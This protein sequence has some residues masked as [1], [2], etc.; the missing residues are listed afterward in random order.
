MTELQPADFAAAPGYKA[1]EQYAKSKA[2]F[3]EGREALDKLEE[4]R[5]NSGKTN[6]ENVTERIYEETEER[7]GIRSTGDLSLRTMVRGS[8]QERRD[9]NL[10]GNENRGPDGRTDDV[11]S[12]ESGSDAGRH[13]YESSRDTGSIKGA[14]R[15][16]LTALQNGRKDIATNLF[17]QYVLAK[18][19][20]AITPILTAAS[21]RGNNVRVTRD[22]K[23]GEFKAV[24]FAAEAMQTYL[25]GDE[26]LVPIPSSKGIATDTLVLAK[27]L[28]AEAGCKV[29]DILESDSRESSYA[30]KQ[31]GKRSLTAD[32]IGTRLKDGV[33]LTNDQIKRIVFID[34]VIST[35]ATAKAAH[36]A[37]G[38]GITLAFS[39]GQA[40]G[41]PN[42]APGI[43][44]ANPV[45]YDDDG[46]VIPLSQRF[47]T[48]SNDIRYSLD[49]ASYIDIQ[50][51]LGAVRN[52]RAA[53]RQREREIGDNPEYISAVED[54][55]NQS[56][57]VTALAADFRDKLKNKTATEEEKTLLRTELG[58][59]KTKLRE[60]EDYVQ[61]IS[62]G[63]GDRLFELSDRENALRKA[64]DVAWEREGAEK[65][66]KAIDKS[67]LSSEDYFRKK[68]S[69]AF[70]YTINF[71]EAGYLLPN[72]EMLDFSDKKNGAP[73]GERARDHREIGE[74]YEATSHTAA[75][76]RFMADGNVRVMAE[77]PGVDIPALHE[78]TP[79]Q[80][81]Q[82]TKMVKTLGAKE[83]AFYID[84]SDADGRGNGGYSYDGNVNADRVINDIKYFYANGS[85][86]EQ[87]P[88]AQFLSEW[89]N[90]DDVNNSEYE[91]S[92]EYE[93]NYSI[94]VTDPETLQQLADAEKNG[95]TM[96]VYRA[97]QAVPVDD[98]GDPYT[99]KFSVL[100][101]VSF[102]PLTVEVKVWR[103]QGKKTVTQ[104]EVRPAKLFSPMAGLTEKEVNGEKKLVWRD[105]IE[106]GRWDMSE[107]HPE[108]A[109]LEIDEETG[110]Y[111]RGKRGELAWFYGLK[112]G[113][114]KENGKNKTDVGARYNP[115]F[116]V[117]LSALND[118][119][120]SAI[121]RP[122]LVTVLCEIPIPEGSVVKDAEVWLEKAKDPLVLCVGTKAQLAAG[123]QS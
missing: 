83:G 77:S 104:I 100:R 60:L 47:N 5:Y 55:L 20:K 90:S 21:Y 106:L 4:L 19:P 115:Y 54:Y 49:T 18:A 107:G 7:T 52:E 23:S 109:Y 122:E 61:K 120:T 51:E 66:Q 62:E 28:A 73:A 116:H 59:E 121:D 102:D 43:K 76:N 113:S 114:V 86:R 98:N 67:G 64:A 24:T 35:G 110:G 71:K 82:I 58:A 40:L 42:T 38:G 79:E 26:I 74:I 68:A 6:A 117:S 13:S 8:E 108:K 37:V 92:L 46:N 97:M 89:D 123:S 80:Y 99:E 81:A 27:T 30:R 70:G 103:K 101:I 56:D 72:G 50:R 17:K 33:V 87:R 112:K 45:T 57:L 15:E 41:G 69:E 111:K 12:A 44:L 94:E 93:A 85:T 1:M 32:E 96:Q 84:F 34:N 105:P 78:P 48:E 9:D 63:I 2:I 53:L 22:L 31:V 25:S 10:F 91:S 119:F 95:R 29:L 75:L 14:E 65:E 11:Y 16:Y 3:D 88:L 118:Q 36:D 39:R